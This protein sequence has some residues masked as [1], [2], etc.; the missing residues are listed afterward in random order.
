MFIPIR[1]KGKFSITLCLH[2]HKYHFDG[3]RRA[4]AAFHAAK[5]LDQPVEERGIWPGG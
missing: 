5:L 3:S 2:N 1:E 4:L